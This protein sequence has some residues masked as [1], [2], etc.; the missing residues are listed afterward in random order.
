MKR[1]ALSYLC[2]AA[3]GLAIWW[4]S[5]GVVWLGDD[6]DYKFMMQGDL[7]QSWGHINSVKEFFQSQFIHYQHVNG[8]F[9]AHSLVQL[10]NAFLGQPTFAVC[11]AAIYVLFAFYLGK[12][13][14]VRFPSNPGGVLSASALSILCF[15][16]KTMPSC[17]IGYIWGMLANLIWLSVFFKKGNHSISQTVV[18]AL[19][20][21][22]VGNWQES[23]SI[24]VCF[25]LSIWWI[26]DLIENRKC[27][28]TLI[29]WDRSRMILG[30]VAGTASNCFAPSTIGRVSRITMTVTD[31]LLVTGYSLPAV[32]V[33]FICVLILV[34]RHKRVG[35]FAMKDSA[36]LIPKGFLAVACI[37][38]LLFNAAIG[39]YSNRQLFGANL[40]AAILVLRILPH[41]RFCGWI[42]ALLAAAVI[43]T[44]GVMY[45]G[46]LD[47]KR[48]YDDIVSLHEE[49]EDGSVEYDRTRQ[50]PF[51]YPMTARYY[52]EILGQFDY[53]LHHSL[54]K[55]FR[56]FREGRTLKLKPTTVPDSE[57]IEQ[58]APGH[59]CVTVRNTA[60]GGREP[61]IIVYG[62]HPW[63]PERIIVRSLEN[64]K[65][66]RSNRQFRTAVII[67]DYPFFVADSVKVK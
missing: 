40:L 31:Q 67:P 47:V 1:D 49:S 43:F 60:N 62:H 4:M 54:M 39:V 29:D 5:T 8:R 13:S 26:C 12:C 27:G 14:D 56:H 45:C 63:S 2:L 22:L 24:G 46:I 30:Y 64:V 17:Q 15:I 9:V 20:G 50:M 34:F 44:W 28:L 35:L 51:G 48:Q 65:Y 19:C 11:N 38:L 21:L 36:G 18:M 6:I 33:L 58:Y 7:W 3:V 57:K 53:D 55:D 61:E 52:E 66:S 25:G 59:F 42:N 23:V 32:L 41:H 10:F 37:S 16:T